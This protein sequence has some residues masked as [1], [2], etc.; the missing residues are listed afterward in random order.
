MADIVVG[1]TEA[2]TLTLAGDYLVEDNSNASGGQTIKSTGTGT[3]TG[4]FT[5]EDGTYEFAVNFFNENDGA[6][7]YVVYVNGIEVETWTG[8][9]GSSGWVIDT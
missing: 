6:S 5:G 3:A 7:E 1:T 9:G 4:A 8:A 2:E